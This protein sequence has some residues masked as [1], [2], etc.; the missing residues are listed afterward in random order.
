MIPNIQEDH[1]GQFGVQAEFEHAFG[2]L[3]R[4]LFELLI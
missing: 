1:L 3:G 2:K 4:P